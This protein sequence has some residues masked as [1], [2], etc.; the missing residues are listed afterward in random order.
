MTYLLVSVKYLYGI[1]KVSVIHK[2]DTIQIPHRYY[3]YFPKLIF[4][5]NICQYPPVVVGVLFEYAPG[6]D[7]PLSV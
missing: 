1:C 3:F 7:Q 5:C 4:T 2:T 6:K